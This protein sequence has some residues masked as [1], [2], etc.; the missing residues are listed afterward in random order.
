M[1]QPGSAQPQTSSEHFKMSAQEPTTTKS[2]SQQGQDE[3]CV[4]AQHKPQSQNHI[5]V[6]V[7]EGTLKT[8]QFLPPAMGRDA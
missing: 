3:Q 2:M 8:I 5:T 1:L 7:L 6:F 4:E